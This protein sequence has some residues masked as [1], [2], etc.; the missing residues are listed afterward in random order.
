MEQTYLVTFTT[1]YIRSRGIFISKFHSAEIAVILQY[2]VLW[3]ACLCSDELGR[4]GDSI[5]GKCGG[6]QTAPERSLRIKLDIPFSVFLLSQ[7]NCLILGLPFDS[8]PLPLKTGL[9][10]FTVRNIFFYLFLIA[11]EPSRPVLL[12][13]PLHPRLHLGAA[14]STCIF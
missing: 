3:I 9:W 1:S 2:S 10:A 13:I 8:L 14:T 5:L 6:G 4:N 7:I 12:Y 11:T